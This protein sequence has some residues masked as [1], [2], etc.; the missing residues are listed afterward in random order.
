MSEEQNKT[1]ELNDEELE[2]AAG[3]AINIFCPN[4]SMKRCPNC[5]DFVRVGASF[6][7]YC[8]YVFK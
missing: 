6:C 5:G 8:Y 1:A 2:Q 7:M 3:G 4:E